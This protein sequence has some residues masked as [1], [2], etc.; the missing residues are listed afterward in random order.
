MLIGECMQSSD[1]NILLVLYSKILG[2]GSLKCLGNK[3]G[4]YTFKLSFRFFY[5][6]TPWMYRIHWELRVGVNSIL[7]S[8]KENSRVKYFITMFNFFSV[9]YFIV[10]TQ[11]RC[12]SSSPDVEGHCWSDGAMSLILLNILCL[13]LKVISH[14][15]CWA[16]DPTLQ[17]TI[18]YPRFHSLHLL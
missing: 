1:A 4:T 6:S 13:F 17:K 10:S 14:Q 5:V 15:C 7:T 9:Y 16:A 18:T 11:A 3:I 2:V 12:K 8:I